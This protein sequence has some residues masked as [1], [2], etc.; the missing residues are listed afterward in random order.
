MILLYLFVGYF[1]AA[2]LLQSLLRWSSLLV[3]TLGRSEGP[4]LPSRR[5]R[6]IWG[7]PL[8][9]LLHPAPY[10]VIGA[11]IAVWKW[12]EGAELLA[13]VAAFSGVGL[14]LMI[15]GHSVVRAYRSSRARA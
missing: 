15:V 8:V 9:A 6:L 11:V 10:L 14:Q 2:F 5:R 12:S 1:A 7:F 4:F 3:T 13:R